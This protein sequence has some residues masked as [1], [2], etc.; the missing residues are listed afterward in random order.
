VSSVVTVVTT[1]SKV[2]SVS[3]LC[4][5]KFVTMV[6]TCAIFTVY[7][8]L[9]LATFITNLTKF[10][11]FLWFC[12]LA[13]P[14]YCIAISYLITCRGVSKG[15]RDKWM[16]GIFWVGQM[17]DWDILGGTQVTVKQ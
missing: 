15:K 17:D 14:F 7:F 10:P 3:N 13:E 5:V 4:M 8:L 9:P 1:V 11:K 6:P 2:T 12:D 16:I